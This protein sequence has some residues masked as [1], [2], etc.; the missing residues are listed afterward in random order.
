MNNT[1]MTN[2]RIA[3]N[4]QSTLR[5][6]SVD[7][8]TEPHGRSAE[9]IQDDIRRTRSQMDDTLTELQRKLSPDRITDE[10]F[11]YLR[12]GGGAEF[13]HNFNEAVKRNPVP[14]A[15]MGIGM[16]WLMMSGREGRYS[17]HNAP[18]RSSGEGMHLGEKLGGAASRVAEAASSA[19]SSAR[20]SLS[21]AAHRV[22][23]AAAS[24]R[25]RLSGAASAGRV[26][27]HSGRER[28]SSAGSQMRERGAYA[29]GRASEY[30]EA[31]RHQAYRAYDTMREQPLLFGAL[32]IAIGAAIGAMLPPT[33][34]EDEWMGEARDRM[35]DRTRH[36]MNEQLDRGKKVAQAAGKAATE[37]AQEEARR[38]SGSDGSGRSDT[39]GGRPSPSL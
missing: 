36:E 14:A 10:V 28:M 24:G 34:R 13:M 32:G 26:R 4:E 21:S 16:A 5:P 8:S 6:H 27:M 7:A 11:S 19:A 33:R 15:M 29:R 2:E 25:E 39:A 37:A 9:E 38:Q 3:R 23:S 1:D 31:A 35:V 18:Y 12:G 17:P 30:S 20:D 22:S